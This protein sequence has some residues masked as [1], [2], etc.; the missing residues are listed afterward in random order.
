[1][2]WLGGGA[3]GHASAGRRTHVL[4]VDKLAPN[5]ATVQVDEVPR[6]HGEHRA[7]D[8]AERHTYQL[9]T[10]YELLLEIGEGA[11]G[12]FL[13]EC[14]VQGR[15]AAAQL[16]RRVSREGLYEA[17]GGELAV[18]G[19]EGV[20]GRVLACLD[21]A[22]H[23]RK[24]VGWVGAGPQNA[25]PLLPNRLARVISCRWVEGGGGAEEVGRHQDYVISQKQCGE[26]V[27][28]EQRR[29]GSP[30]RLYAQRNHYGP[31]QTSVTL[32]LR[33]RSTRLK[34]PGED[35]AAKT[36]NRERV[37]GR[38]ERRHLDRVEV[39]DLGLTRG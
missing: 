10:K 20:L 15:L 39:D 5:L 27:E 17:A 29:H 8:I 16:L 22:K 14:L 11:E 25:N 6:V 12:P 24:S 1:M 34:N 28:L 30:R 4:Y 2:A 3:V 18:G 38:G 21:V 36:G 35:E 33:R 37:G 26:R 31:R 9:M 32:L 19:A 7:R 13:V 23:V